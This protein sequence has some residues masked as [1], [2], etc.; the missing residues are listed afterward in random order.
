M[1]VVT[2]WLIPEAEQSQAIPQLH[3]LRDLFA[4]GGAEMVTLGRSLDNPQLW[5]LM[6][7]WPK[8]GQY[9]RC[10]SSYPIKMAIGPI[11]HFIVDEPSVYEVMGIGTE[12][13]QAK[14]RSLS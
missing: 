9:R 6:T 4:A 13:N 10:L 2:R 7:T 11:M 3:D 14:P 8:V 5:M 1:V 12:G